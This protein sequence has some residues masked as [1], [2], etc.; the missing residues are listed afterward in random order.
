MMA[1]PTKP[2]AGVTWGHTSRHR[3]HEIQRESGYI[4]SCCSGAMRGPGPR[5]YVPSTGTQAFTRFRFSK[6]TLRSTARSRITGKRDKGS[7]RTGCSNLLIRDEHA[8]AAFPLISM[9]HDPQTSSRQLDSY[10]IG[11]VG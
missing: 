10:E 4:S 1:A 9:A 11:V 8:M 5:S 6:S 3:Q 2:V 7:R